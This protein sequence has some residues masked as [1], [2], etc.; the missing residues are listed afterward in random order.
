MELFNQLPEKIKNDIY[1]IVFDDLKYDFERE[2]L[3]CKNLKL[4]KEEEKLNELNYG[5]YCFH[6]I[7]QHDITNEQRIDAL[8]SYMSRYIFH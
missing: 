2:N 8:L 3:G 6:G 7:N 4:S 5:K 1:F